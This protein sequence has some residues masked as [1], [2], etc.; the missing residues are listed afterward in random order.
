MLGVT[1]FAGEYSGFHELFTGETPF[2]NE[3]NRWMALLGV[4]TLGISQGFRAAH[5]LSDLAGVTRADPMEIM[6]TQSTVSKNFSDGRSINDTV[7]ELIDAPGLVDRIPAIRVV[8]DG[9]VKRT[10]DNRRLTCFLAAGCKNIPVK[11]LDI[12]DMEVF[13]EK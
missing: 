3:E 12:N 5:R 11:Q 7:A 6:Y 10:L 1:P 9:N 4:A 13:E 8:Q 2:G